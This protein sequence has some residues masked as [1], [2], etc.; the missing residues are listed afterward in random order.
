MEP[1]GVIRSQQCH[2]N[3]RS[4]IDSQQEPLNNTSSHHEPMEPSK[5]EWII[6]SHNFPLDCEPPMEMGSHHK[7]LFVSRSDLK[8]SSEV[9]KP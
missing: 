1:S 9:I 6:G 8:S 5:E 2:K 7:P 4:K 3:I